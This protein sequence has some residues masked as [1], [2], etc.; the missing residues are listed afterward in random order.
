MK[1]TITNE[2]RPNDVVRNSNELYHS[3]DQS[4]HDRNTDTMSEFHKDW[5]N[6]YDQG[7][8][9]TGTTNAPRL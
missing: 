5:E 3:P 8:H 9:N 2:N 1:T 4:Q 6:N 7:M